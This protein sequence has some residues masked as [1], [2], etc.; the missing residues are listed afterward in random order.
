[1]TVYNVINVNLQD[2]QGR[3]TSLGLVLQS[4]VVTLAGAQSAFDAW[5]GLYTAAGGGG[6]LSASVTFPLTVVPT[7]P[8][9]DSKI[10]DTAWVK[11]L[12]ADGRKP[13]YGFPMPKKTA[14][15][16]NWIV[17]GAVVK[18]DAD[19][20]AYFDQFLPAGAL[21]YGKYTATVLASAGGIIGGYLDKD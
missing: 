2:G 20:I 10:G 21:A 7:T 15:V 1:M 17:G 13:S 3:E 11:L 8:D 16:P 14:G 5:D 19:L 4:D 6:I 9:D 18:T 12:L